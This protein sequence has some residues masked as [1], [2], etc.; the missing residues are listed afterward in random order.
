MDAG[1]AATCSMLPR[2]P[3]T[4]DM[5]VYENDG[6]LE[7]LVSWLNE[8]GQREG[9]LRAALLRAFPQQLLQ[10]QQQQPPPPPPPSP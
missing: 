10:Q 5:T 6:D 7:A 2:R 8:S 4:E 3:V 1:A 9:P